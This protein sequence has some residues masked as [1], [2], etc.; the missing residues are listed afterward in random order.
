MNSQAVESYLKQ[1]QLLSFQQDRE[2]SALQELL[3]LIEQNLDESISD[4]PNQEFYKGEYAFY[5][6]QYE[7]ALKHYLQCKGIPNYEFFCYRTSAYLA[8]GQGYLDKALTFIRKALEVFPDDQQSL[9]FL[10]KLSLP[11][12]SQQQ[13]EV[14]S[15]NVPLSTNTAERVEVGAEAGQLEAPNVK[16]TISDHAI[17]ELAGIFSSSSSEDVLFAAEEVREKHASF[18]GVHVDLFSEDLDLADT[19]TAVAILEDSLKESSTI[20]L[21][22]D[23]PSFSQS[24]SQITA[25]YLRLW[26]KRASLPAQGLYT[27]HGWDESVANFSPQSQWKLLSESSRKST[28]GF[29]LHWHGKG[30]VINPGRSFLEQ[31]HRRGLFVKDIDSVI[32]TQEHMDAYA[33]IKEI[34]ELNYQIN[35][36]CDQP[37]L[38][39]YY[40]NQKAY[41]HLSGVLKPRFK[42]ERYTVHTLELFMDA[43]MEHME[44]SPEISMDYFVTSAQSTTTMTPGYERVSAPSGNLGLRLLLK[45]N[46][47]QMTLGYIAGA[48]WTP[49]LSQHLGVCDFLLVGV[50]NTNSADYHKKSY[51][52]NQLGFFGVSSLLE[53]H[54]PKVLVCTEFGGRE[55]DLR[56]EM[57]R[58]IRQE[59]QQRR[60][61]KEP[62]TAILPSDRGFFLDL[63]TNCVRCS[64]TGQFTDAR[65][66]RVIR[67]AGAFSELLYL[68]NASCL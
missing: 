4:L 63:K 39:H 41:H 50:G 17:K 68:S 18:S 56:L 3:H 19:H 31:F 12:M 28:G 14:A 66:I 13:S 48:G 65:H 58:K 10:A 27:F 30:V 29:Y 6:G 15:E 16:M 22:D 51:L 1:V 36:A 60:P 49:A 2:P 9:A 42:Q 46:A 52:P 7:Q 32:V 11:I 33:D 5:S 45:D 64:A 61:T 44:L 43:D 38:I 59:W 40:L 57:V 34:Y 24:S 54:P 23:I 20:K 8:D 55:G 25:D 21:L 26:Q 37:H 35:Q 62:T 67:S 47:H 53:T